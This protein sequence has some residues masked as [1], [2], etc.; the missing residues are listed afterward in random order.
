[1]FD[2]AGNPESVSEPPDAVPPLPDPLPVSTPPLLEPPELPRP[3]ELPE[4]PEPPA[5]E[6]ELEP[7]ELEVPCAS[8]VDGD[9]AQ[10]AI[11]SGATI[12][13]PTPTCTRKCSIVSGDAKAPLDVQ[14]GGHI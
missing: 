1:L 2:P 9:E 13:N 12:N 3:L 14:A 4:P 5:V 10:E 11:V 7:P 6:L 8:P